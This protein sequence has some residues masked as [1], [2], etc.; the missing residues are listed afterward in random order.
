MI[1]PNYILR[2]GRIALVNGPITVKNGI[3]ALAGWSDN[4]WFRPPKTEFTVIVI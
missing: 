3:A 2:N 4:V 1:E